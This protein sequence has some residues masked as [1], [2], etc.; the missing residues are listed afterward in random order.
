[1]STK[2]IEFHLSDQRSPNLETILRARTI[3]QPQIRSSRKDW[4]IGP[5]D[6]LAD[7]E[8]GFLIGGKLASNCKQNRTLPFGGMALL[9]GVCGFWDASLRGREISWMSAR[10]RGFWLARYASER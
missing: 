8:L 4:S 5:A 7:I 6:R 10:K 9:V 2:K 1:V 3:L